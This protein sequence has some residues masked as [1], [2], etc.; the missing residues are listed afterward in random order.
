M[1]QLR[2]F[3]ITQKKK[4]TKPK[5]N[6]ETGKNKGKNK[7][8]KKVLDHKYG[9]VTARL[10]WATVETVQIKAQLQVGKAMPPSPRHKGDGRVQGAPVAPS[11]WKQIMSFEN[12]SSVCFTKK[13]NSYKYNLNAFLLPFYFLLPSICRKRSE[14]SWTGQE[15]CV[16]TVNSCSQ[17]KCSPNLSRSCLVI[18]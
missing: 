7:E 17:R 8:T 18:D 5:I 6:K 16:Q 14:A 10:R 2:I 4:K 12:T 13:N 3:S 1:Q 11:V 9:V 15:T